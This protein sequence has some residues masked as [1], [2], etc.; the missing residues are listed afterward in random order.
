MKWHKTN[1][2]TKLVSL[3]V[4]FVIDVNVWLYT[5]RFV[6]TRRYMLMQNRGL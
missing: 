2:L 5:M 3:F 6:S 1:R 4:L